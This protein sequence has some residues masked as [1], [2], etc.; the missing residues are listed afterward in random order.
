[1]FD[2]KAKKS[3]YKQWW[4]WLIVIAIFL[5]LIFG[6]PLIINNCYI[7]NSGY[8]TVWGGDDVL[9]F[10]GS[11]LSFIGTVSL[12][13]LALWQNHILSKQNDNYQKILELKDIP[14]LEIKFNGFSGLLS[15]PSVK[16]VNLTNNIATNFVVEKC[17]I[18][19]TENSKYFYEY[20]IRKRHQSHFKGYD[21]FIIEFL[22]GEKTSKLIMSF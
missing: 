13:I 4:I 14:I 6:I 12:G 5:F 21:E 17:G 16:V 22:D 18:K 1:M 20:T 11:I 3:W 15:N 19:T 8:I 7:P 2:I 10:Y 9:Q